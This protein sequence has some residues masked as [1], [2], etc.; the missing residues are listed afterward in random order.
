VLHMQ[1]QQH[2]NSITECTRQ[3]TYLVQ[4]VEPVVPDGC[5][6]H[7]CIGAQ[8]ASPGHIIG[9][10]TPAATLTSGVLGNTIADDGSNDACAHH[11]TSSKEP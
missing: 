2:H 3:N 11:D 5:T 8:P 6:N 9:W 7:C 4:E 1:Q 10:C